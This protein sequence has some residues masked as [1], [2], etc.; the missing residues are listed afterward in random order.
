MYCD[1]FIVEFFTRDRQTKNLFIVSSRFSFECRTIRNKTKNSFR[2]AEDFFKSVRIG[3]QI[4][5]YESVVYGSRFS[6]GF[7]CV[8]KELRRQGAHASMK[9]LHGV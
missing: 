3:M 2:S 9:V 5:A 7:L 4:E 8:C 6:V 1:F